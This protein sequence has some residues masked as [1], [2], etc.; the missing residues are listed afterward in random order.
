MNSEK[1]SSFWLGLI[2]LFVFF[3]IAIGILHEILSAPWQFITILIGITGTIAASLFALIS[4]INEQILNEQIPKKVEIYQKVINLLLGV[5]FADK[6]QKQN[7][8]PYEI[9]KALLEFTPDLI[10]LFWV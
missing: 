9:E 8:K 5:V 10:R 6:L 4:K 1:S 2:A 7:L 3:L